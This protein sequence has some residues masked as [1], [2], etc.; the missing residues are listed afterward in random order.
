LASSQEKSFDKDSITQVLFTKSC[1]LDSDL[2]QDDKEDHKQRDLMFYNTNMDILKR[3]RFIYYIE[4]NFFS[5]KYPVIRLEGDVDINDKNFYKYEHKNIVFTD[6]IL[7]VNKNIEGSIAV[8]NGRVIIDPN[9]GYENYIYLYNS[10]LQVDSSFKNFFIVCANEDQIVAF[11]NNRALQFA[12]EKSTPYYIYDYLKGGP[13]FKYNRV[14]G[15]FF[16]LSIDKSFYW[17]EAKNY[18][19]SATTGYAFGNHRWTGS[20]AI[21]YWIGN[22]D[23]IEF[24]GEVFSLTDSKDNWRISDIE[25]TLSS[26]FIHEDFKDYFLREGYLFHITKY[27][28]KIFEF[29]IT[30]IQDNYKSQQKNY[31]WAMFGGHK[32][33]RDN[34]SVLNGIIRSFVF[35][36]NYNSYAKDYYLTGWDINSEFEIANGVSKYNKFVLYVRNYSLLKNIISFINNSQVRFNTRLMFGTAD[37][38]LPFQKS[39]DIGGLGTVPATNFKTLNGNKMLL[40][41]LEFSYPTLE[42]LGINSMNL[43][44][45]LT[46]I[47]IS[48][49]IGFTCNSISNTLFSGFNINKETVLHGVSIALGTFRDRIRLGLAFR[50]DKSESPRL[51]FRVARPF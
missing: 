17:N 37:Q 22:E 18:S 36:C 43:S 29:G 8:F 41:N 13:T 5:K 3:S 31:D 15:P 48:Y 50:L 44:E 24:G 14:E 7:R 46:N 2:K 32:K 49:D 45:D 11:E 20:L 28:S 25:N 39:F 51:I 30:F 47:I 10:Y 12:I 33:F 40:A 27:Y 34:P 35:S 21:D 42:L 19:Y 16:G 6:G 38:N 1:F 4:N 23:R 9:S 26:L